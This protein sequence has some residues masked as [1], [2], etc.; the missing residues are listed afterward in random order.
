MDGRISQLRQ[1]WRK[2]RVMIHILNMGMNHETAPVDLR[3]CLAGEPAKG[4]SLL[5][6]LKCVPSIRESLYL[7]TCNRVELV[8]VTEELDAASEDLKNLLCSIGNVDR[9]TLL[10]SLYLYQDME[11]VTHIFRVASSLDS[12]IVGEPQIL[13]QVKEAY[14]RAVKEKTS[15]VILNRLMHRAFRAAKRVRTET[16]ISSSA[17]SVSYAAVELAKKI[18]NVLD[19]K[20]VL[21][22]GAGEMAELAA[23]HLVSHGVRKQCAWRNSLGQRRFPLR[24]GLAGSWMPT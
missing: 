2:K 12:M 3:E 8:A 18:F 11:A 7:T 1:P 20:V 5:R 14:A 21:L 16:G 24:R 17:V 6:D 13:G 22:I 10:P 9:K 4:E 15:G 19:D 23:R